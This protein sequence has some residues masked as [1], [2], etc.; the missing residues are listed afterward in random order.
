MMKNIT[1]IFLIFLVIHSCKRQ[2]EISFSDFDKDNNKSIERDEFVEAFTSYYTKDWNNRE[3]NYFDDENLY[4]SVFDIWD[5]DN[6]QLLDSNEW[7]NAYDNYFKD[8]I[9]NDFSVIDLN[10]SEYIEFHEFSR[11]IT[12]SDFFKLWDTDENSFLSQEE[13]AIGVF[14]KWDQ[15]KNGEINSEEFDRFINYYQIK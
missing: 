6:D 7:S 14:S 10:R 1:V 13:L 9:I 8:Y 2:S 5:S 3:N 11:A 4:R 15:N 12:D